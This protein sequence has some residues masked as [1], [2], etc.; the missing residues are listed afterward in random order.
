MRVQ[1]EQIFPCD[2][3]YLFQEIQKIE[4]FFYITAP[5]IKFV[6]CEPI[7]SDTWQDGHYPMKMYL[8][9]FIPLG[10]QSVVIEQDEAHLRMRDNGKSERLDQW[11]HRIQVESIGENRAKYTDCIDVE[12]G[13]WTLP[14]AWFVHLFFRYRQYRWRKRIREKLKVKKE[15]STRL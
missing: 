5:L 15:K 1:I 3:Q 13:I 10:K 6:P 11:D 4:N 8:L 7:L 12:A 9:S 14:V 2:A